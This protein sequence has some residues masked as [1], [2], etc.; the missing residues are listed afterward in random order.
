VFKQIYIPKTLQEL[1]TEEIA[2]MSKN[3]DQAHVYE[4]LTGKKPES[5]EVKQA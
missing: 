1:T 4:T 3:P 5:F 2:I